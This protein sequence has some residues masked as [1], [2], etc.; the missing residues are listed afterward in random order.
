MNELQ[1]GAY[2]ALVTPLDAGG[3]LAEESLARLLE[4]LSRA[5]LSGYV[6]LGS[7]G[8]CASLPHHLRHTV[9]RKVRE[10]LGAKATVLAG[11]VE[12]SLEEAIAE[13]EQAAK[14]GMDAILVPPPF[15]FP[16]ADQEV[17]AFY[18]AL[19][20]ASPLP[21]VLYNIPQYTK[22]V[23]PVEVVR[24]LAS[25]PK[26]A[27]IKDSSGDMRYFGACVEASEAARPHFRCFTGADDLLL[28][29]LAQGGDGTICSSANVL[30]EV[31]VEVI[32]RWRA[33]DLQGALRA[34]RRSA[35]LI[36][37]AHRLGGHRAW[38]ACVELLGAAPCRVAPPYV[39][40]VEGERNAL[41]Q[42]LAAVEAPTID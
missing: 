24:T 16:M 22:V 38:K 3:R 18:T 17:L 29:S 13:A 32:D 40:L 12:T 34:Q 41:K 36:R 19:A 30:P 4:R 14:A 11:V 33:G 39:E 37:T 5:G 21:I 1:D 20:E 9:M 7:T 2:V 23:I 6:A 27:A 25:H 35:R 8:E 15:Y 42:V 31:S 26:V 28:A 10:Q